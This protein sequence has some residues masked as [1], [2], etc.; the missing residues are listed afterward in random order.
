MAQCKPRKC[1]HDMKT[2]INI[3]PKQVSLQYAIP[4]TNKG[5]DWI[6]NPSSSE[7]EIIFLMT[8]DKTSCV[9]EQ[10]QLPEV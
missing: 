4:K 6:K 2:I 10:P 8:N 9:P 7:L 3:N 5:R 1:C